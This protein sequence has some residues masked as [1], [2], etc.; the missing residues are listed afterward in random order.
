MAR[1][2]FLFIDI[3][4]LFACSF[5]SRIALNHSTIFHKGTC[6]KEELNLAKITAG[7]EM[8]SRGPVEK[9]KGAH[10]FLHETP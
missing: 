1:H 8:G 3:S 5:I 10:R 4:C 7:L 2:H 6:A 9:P